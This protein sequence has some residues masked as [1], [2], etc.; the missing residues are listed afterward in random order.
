MET[1]LTVGMAT[2]TRCLC[3]I[4]R[5]AGNLDSNAREVEGHDLAIG[6]L[7]YC[8]GSKGTLAHGVV[9]DPITRLR[10]RH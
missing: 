7:H 2:K 10:E 1:R 5:A 3:S 8:E 6:V 4:A 9:P